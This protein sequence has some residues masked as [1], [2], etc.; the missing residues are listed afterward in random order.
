MDQVLSILPL[1]LRK[2][3]MEIM[4]ALSSQVIHGPLF[5]VRKLIDKNVDTGIGMSPEE[6]R[7]NL[8]RLYCIAFSSF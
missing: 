7:T 1:N 3:K 8:V 5:F 2:M 4:V 6:L